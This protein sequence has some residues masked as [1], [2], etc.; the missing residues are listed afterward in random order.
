MNSGVYISH[1]CMTGEHSMPLHVTSNRH[2]ISIIVT[3]S[4]EDITPLHSTITTISDENGIPLHS[5]Y[6][7]DE[8]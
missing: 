8:G 7:F 2:F 1:P 5:H 4:G 6:Q 3:I